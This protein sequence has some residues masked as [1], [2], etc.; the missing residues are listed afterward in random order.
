[1]WDKD[2]DQID[3]DIM[4]EQT[5]GKKDKLIDEM[6]DFLKEVDEL[7]NH[8]QDAPDDIPDF[9]GKRWSKRTRM[10]E[11]EIDEMPIEAIIRR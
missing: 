2:W 11:M 3:R 1:M 5:V 10:H 6:H 8:N 7:I 4:F 9:K